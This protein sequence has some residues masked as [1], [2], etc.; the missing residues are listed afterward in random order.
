MGSHLGKIFGAIIVLLFSGCILDISKDIGATGTVIILNDGVMPSTYIY[1]LGFR[2]YSISDFNLDNA[3]LLKGGTIVNLDSR[4]YRIS[5]G[6]YV[7]V[8][9]T[10]YPG[11]SSSYDNYSSVI[12]VNKDETMTIR[13]NNF[14][15]NSYW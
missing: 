3:D 12:T 1:K 7:I 14:G 6:K 15:T 10:Y 2:P 11:T 8:A 5:P 9:K 4:S 13:R